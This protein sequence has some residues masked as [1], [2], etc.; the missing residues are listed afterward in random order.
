M[1][2]FISSLVA[3]FPH[4]EEVERVEK[5]NLPVEGC[6]DE[7]DVFHV[8]NAR[9]WFLLLLLSAA[10]HLLFTLLFF[11]ALLFLLSGVGIA[12][13]HEFIFAV[14]AHILE[15]ILTD[16][17]QLDASFRGLPLETFTA[18]TF[19]LAIFLIR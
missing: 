9:D 10:C 14:G 16:R 12:F 6:D 5:F 17:V 13:G 4:S 7:S 2:I 19:V 15:V 11:L 18:L 1:L 3:V 8:L